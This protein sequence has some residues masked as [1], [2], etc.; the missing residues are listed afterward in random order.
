[1]SR[2]WIWIA[3]WFVLAGVGIWQ[4]WR[5]APRDAWG[6]DPRRAFIDEMNSANARIGFRT[7]DPEAIERGERGVFLA[8]P[9]GA[10]DAVQAA[11]RLRWKSNGLGCELDTNRFAAEDGEQFANRVGSDAAAM[12]RVFPVEAR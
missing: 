4:T 6:R 10:V 3:M 11:M 5:S 1:M 7:P 12:L 9:D 8:K 2:P